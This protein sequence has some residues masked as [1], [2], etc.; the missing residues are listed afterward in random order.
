MTDEACWLSHTLPS[1]LPRTC[2]YKTRK[3][4]MKLLLGPFLV[5]FPSLHFF[6]YWIHTGFLQS[7][8]LQVL[9]GKN[10]GQLSTNQFIAVSDQSGLL[11]L[12]TLFDIEALSVYDMI[13]LQHQYDLKKKLH[14]QFIEKVISLN[15]YDHQLF[16]NQYYCLHFS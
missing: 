10:H 14:T 9:E 6:F 13:N 11:I 15:K 16:K 5:S 4:E 8:G 12:A 1:K 7:Q 3:L 2:S